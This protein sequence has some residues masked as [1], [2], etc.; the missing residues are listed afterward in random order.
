MAKAAH[1]LAIKKQERKS[2][3]L[4]TIKTLYLNEL[5]LNLFITNF[6]IDPN[7]QINQPIIDKLLK[8]GAIAA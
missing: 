8:I 6:Q 4:A 3:S 5:M 2:F 1:Y 7:L